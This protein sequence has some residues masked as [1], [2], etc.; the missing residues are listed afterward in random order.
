LAEI[1]AM[2]SGA[3][4]TLFLRFSTTEA[5]LK[6]RFIAVPN[7]IAS[8]KVFPLNRIRFYLRSVISVI[9]KTFARA[10][11]RLAPALVFLYELKTS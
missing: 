10:K 11:I 9:D 8:A 1:P 6:A 2:N 7:P 4:S 3:I 5:K